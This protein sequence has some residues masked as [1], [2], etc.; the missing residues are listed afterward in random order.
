MIVGFTGTRKGMSES[1]KRQ[2]VLV[3]R[4]FYR[5]HETTEFHHGAA[6]GADQE[7]V[8]LAVGV[9]YTSVPHPAGADP[10][11]RNRDIAEACDVL[12]AAP[13]KD[14]EELRSGTWAT[15]RYA[16][17]ERKPVVMLTRGVR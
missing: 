11:E 2:L 14:T 8:L 4:Y 12:I 3:L 1:Q 17:H 5:T 7:A 13:V 10:L 15:V 9:G 16:R 6:D